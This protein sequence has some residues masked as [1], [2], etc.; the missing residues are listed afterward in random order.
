MSE[1][2][3]IK[4][5]SQILTAAK[6]TGGGTYWGYWGPI[7]VNEYSTMWQFGL[8]GGLTFKLGK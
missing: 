8:G 1:K 3:G 4:I 6:V 5:Q 2:F 7:Y